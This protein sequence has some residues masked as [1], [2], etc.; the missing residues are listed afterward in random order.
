MT[1]SR[2]ITLVQH[3]RKT[4]NIASAAFMVAAHTN[5]DKVHFSK[6]KWS[7][8]IISLITQPR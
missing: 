3:P 5:E 4:I 6:D 2:N 1:S 8:K 7:L